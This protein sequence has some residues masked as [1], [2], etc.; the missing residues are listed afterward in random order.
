MVIKKIRMHQTE[1]MIEGAFQRRSQIDFFVL[2]KIIHFQ[3]IIMEFANI[4]V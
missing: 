2:H 4:C 3:I 1:L